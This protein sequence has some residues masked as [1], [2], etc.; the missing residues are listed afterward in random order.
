[1]QN[2]FEVEG[3]ACNYEKAEELLSKDA[4]ADRYAV[5]LT[6][7][8]VDLGR[9]RPIRRRAT[10]ASSQ[11]AAGTPELSVHGGEVAGDSQK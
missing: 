8:R 6:R 10:C 5:S 9:L 3:P 2:F 11:A 1:M 4:R 7:G